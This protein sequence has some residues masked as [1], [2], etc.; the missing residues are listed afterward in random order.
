VL[1]FNVDGDFGDV[2]DA[3]MVIDLTK[4]NP[5]I[6]SR[7]MGKEGAASFLGHHGIKL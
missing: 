5:A 6:L 4:T 7:Y 2:L 3:L 1:A